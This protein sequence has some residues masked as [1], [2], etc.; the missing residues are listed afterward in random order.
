[1]IKIGNEELIKSRG[2]F[3]LDSLHVRKYSFEFPTSGSSKQSLTVEFVPFAYLDDG[4]RVYDLD[5]TYKVYIS[6]VEAYLSSNP[7]YS[8]ISAYFS[9][10][11]GLA[12]ILGKKIPKLQASFIPP[13]GM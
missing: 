1:M 9:T 12:D 6:D 10:E 4:S 5:T 2:D 8:V 11:A 3:K 13:E 7:L